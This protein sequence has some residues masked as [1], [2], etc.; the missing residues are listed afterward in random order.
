MTNSNSQEQSPEP[1]K[2]GGKA[3][4]WGIRGSAARK[5]ALLGLAL[6]WL[7][8]PRQVGAAN[9]TLDCD[10]VSTGG[11]NSSGSTYSI[12]DTAGQPLAGVSSAGAYTLEDGFWPGMNTAPLP[13][14][15]TLTRATNRTAKVAIATLLA[16]DADL[17]DD[18]FGLTTVD[19][20]TANGG[21]ITTDNGWVR[22]TPATGFNGSDTFTYTVTDAEG[23]SATGSVL[24]QMAGD[25]TD[26]GRTLV[27]LTTLAD[28]TRSLRFV[29]IAGR[30]F[31]IQ[32]TSDLTTPDWQE[33]GTSVAGA[34]GLFEFVDTELPA[35]AQ[36]YYRAVTY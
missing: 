6:L 17:D 7:M 31:S 11:G 4:N 15:D 1:R 10:V 34:N 22:Y 27:Q 35:P 20:V 2:R 18:A 12:R 32:A 21:T 28:G 13:V 8:S 33:L 9:Y 26:Q 23:Y 24:I 30:T 14:Q 3:V 36:R 25:T 29:G 5:S 19:A 16:N